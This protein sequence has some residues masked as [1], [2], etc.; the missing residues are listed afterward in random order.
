MDYYFWA[1]KKESNGKLL[2]LPL[3]QHLE[4]TMNVAGLLWEHWLGE[5]Q[6]QLIE[7]SLSSSQSNDGL[8]KQVIQFL[9]ATHDLGKATPAFQ[10]Q[11][12]YANSED[13]DIQLL[14]KLE[15]AGFAG[16]SFVDLANPR[17]SHHSIAGQYL[18]SRYGVHDDLATI[19]GGHH[20]KPIDHVDDYK[21]QK[22]YE[23]NFF[24]TEKPDS[25]I[26]RKWDR[27]QRDIFEWALEI[28]GFSSVE[29]L[30]R[31]KQPA[32]V[33]LSGLLIMA[34]WI[35]S[36]ED[37]FPL[38]SVEENKIEE[39]TTR[40]ETGFMKWKQSGLWV[41]FI[42]GTVDIFK[43]RFEFEPHYVQRVL[44]DKI[45]QS[46]NPG[47]FVLEAPMGTGKTEAALIAAEQLAAKTGRNGLYFGLPTQA[48]SNGIFSR[49]EKWVESI[50]AEQNID[51]PLSIHLVH[52][53][54]ALNEQFS[55]LPR[56]SNINIDDNDNDSV[57]VNEWF[58]GRKTTALD[59]FVV[60]TVDQFLMVALKQKH[61][62]LRHLGFSKKVV[63][64]DE[65]HAYDAYMNQ[66]LLE[67]IKWMGAYGVPV[68]IL[69]ATLP[70]ERR[71]ALVTNYLNGTGEKFPKSERKS[72]SDK[73]GS[74][75]YPLI[76]YTDGF[77]IY[78]ETDFPK[79]DSKDITICRLQ[80]KNLIEMI[81]NQLSEGGVV[82][83]IMNTVRRAQD[84]AKYLSEKFGEDMV[85]LLHS[86]F[87]ATDRIRKEQNLL[88]MIGRDVD[89]P[90][91]KIIIGTQV[92]EQSLDIDFD[93]LISDL[94][95]M[96]L[97]IQ[98]MGRLHRHDIERP[99]KHQK[100]NFYVL[101]MAD[102]LDFES[103]ASFVYG[104]Y[105]LTRTQYFLPNIVS[106][107]ED[108]SS[109]VQKVYGNS[110]IDFEDETLNKKYQV[111]KN[112]HDIK[113]E[114]QKNK[115][116]N[117][118]IADPVLVEK[119]SRKGNLIGWL[120]N[121]NP[122]E[123][124]EKSYA[125]VRDIEETIEV[126][127]LK[128]VESGYGLFGKDKDISDYITD[129]QLAREVAQNTLRLPQSLSKSYNIDQSIK[130]LENYNNQHLPTWRKSTWLKG[131]LGIIFD[132]NNEFVFNGR[133]LR[134]NEQYGISMEEVE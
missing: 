57:A 125:Q 67:A 55:E 64:I 75:A 121:P 128:K 93:V 16:I 5:G 87:I 126:I 85:E 114:R 29:E 48:T 108:I 76:T 69:S 116:K 40:L 61:L 82:G 58:S 94:A 23:S 43:K 112:E 104:D 123:S 84:L 77:D 8:G 122:T 131:A 15:R 12:G 110:D 7:A 90:E 72:L 132:E 50:A 22:D 83:L 3:M 106:I 65:V 119:G 105:L 34:D 36:N 35:A 4:D 100:P 81:R 71:I 101:G 19:V 97:L 2:W 56:S 86:G 68:V 6:R 14:E 74:E 42:K 32:Q 13:L 102:N 63:V 30:P 31:V 59:D 1:K 24:Q 115:A 39:Q 45:L 91:R 89:R 66:Y 99:V 127:A 80:E 92:I 129:Y 25:T 27:A 79:Q 118:R 33:I 54:A 88:Q 11:K 38:I 28:S 47:I 73:F 78:Q 9:A 113:I 18:L 133:K 37:Y 117:Y 130:E 109:L 49:I 46:Q 96:D 41:P 51:E 98:R 10:T 95:P 44:S 103:G 107:P 134:Y 21:T 70:A 52:G 17:E 124:E 20:G 62:A 26:Y 60:G 120:K 53:K 111:A